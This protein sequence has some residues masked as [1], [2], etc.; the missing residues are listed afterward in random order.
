MDFLKLARGVEKEVIAM[1]RDFHAHPEMGFEEVRT[2]LVIE[3]RLKRLGIKTRRMA[4]TGVVGYLERGGAKKT[5]AL[6]AD[7]DALPIAEETK[8]P[9]ASKTNLMHACGHDAHAAM[10]LGVAKILSRIRGDLAGNVRFI[11]QPS[12]E[13]PPGGARA[14][15]REGV[16]DGVDEVYGLH[17]WSKLASGR[18][19]ADAGAIMAN[20][21]DVRIQIIGRGAHGASPNFSIDPV[22][23]A[24]EAIVA[25]QQIVSRNLSP[26]EPGVLSICMINAGTA[27]NI[28]PEQCAFRGTVRTLTKGLRNNMPRMIRRVVAGV[29]K[30]HGA[31]FE[32]E[33]LAGYDALVNDRRATG[34]V[35]EMIADM[36][37]GEALKE[38]GP[39]MGAE[40]FSEYLK[41]ARG[42]FFMLGTGNRR[43]GTDV[44]H[45][46]PR[47]R[48]DESA[49]WRGVAV[50]ARLAVERARR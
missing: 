26:M 45:H 37:G 20:V 50:M 42:C 22:L 32:M 15:I 17:V 23:T 43:L 46:N 9:F 13:F 18:L 5:V 29:A 12:E 1:R 28:I 36:F 39:R 19:A 38:L 40:D 33:Y 8:L 6:R 7:I 16:M 24:S 11:F 30:A 27:Y 3:K 44:S 10:L 21:D 25:L 47:F 2:A 49:L 48:V 34:W 4:G 14:M 35:R 31:K 41:L